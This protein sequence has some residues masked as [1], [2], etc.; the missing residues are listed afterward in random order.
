MGV[1]RGTAV[2][3][4]QQSTVNGERLTVGEKGRQLWGNGRWIVGLVW[5]TDRRLLAGLVAMTLVLS[6]LPAVLAVVVRGLVNEVA[7]ILAGEVGTATQMLLWLGAGLGITLVET[8]GNFI[9]RYLGQR[10]KDELN[11]RITGDILAHAAKLDVS[12]FESPRFQDMMERAQQNTAQRF[13]RFVTNGLSVVTNFFQVVSLALILV[14]IEPLVVAA[15]APLA[16]RIKIAF[17]HGS[18]AEGREDR[19]SDVDL[20][21]VGEVTF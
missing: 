1:L 15:L 9:N 3:N 17:V 11:L 18:V 14:V 10:L 4:S 12:Y 2:S 19:Q 20:V 16:N 21:V 8:V 13:S 6:V 5:Q 7:A